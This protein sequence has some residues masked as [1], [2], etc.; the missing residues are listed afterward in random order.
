MIIAFSRFYQREKVPK[1]DEGEHAIALR[2]E[3]K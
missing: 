2:K 3:A 1:G